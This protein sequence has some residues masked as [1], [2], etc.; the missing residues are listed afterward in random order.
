MAKLYFRYGTM[1]CGKSIDLL[2][3]A[4]NYRERGQIPLLITSSIDDRYGPCKIT[5]RIGLS[6]SAYAFNQQDNVFAYISNIKEEVD[7]VLV[8]EAQFFTNQQIR[9]LSDVVDILN[10]PVICYGLRA[11]FQNKLFCGSE[12]LL[13]IADKIEELKTMC[14][15]GKKATCNLRIINNEIIT[16][17]K[18]I[19]IGGNESYLPV[20]RNCFKKYVTMPKNF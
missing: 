7:V 5:T 8:D 16:E 17:G 13:A 20:C 19:F 18:Q 12:E 10:I 14:E 9:Q 2:K 1:G 4:Y 15:C 11:D 3:V 6:E